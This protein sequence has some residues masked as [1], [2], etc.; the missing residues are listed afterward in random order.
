MKAYTDPPKATAAA[1]E[2]LSTAVG[3]MADAPLVPVQEIVD[4]KLVALRTAITGQA[5]QIGNPMK[6]AILKGRLDAID[7]G[8]QRR[9]SFNPL[10]PLAVSGACRVEGVNRLL[11]RGR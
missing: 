10:H 1:L 5:T 4:Q 9:V 3:V 2:A 7:N 8:L 6:N 11:P